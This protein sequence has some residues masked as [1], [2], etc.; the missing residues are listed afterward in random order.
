[1]IRVTGRPS[2]S[3]VTHLSHSHGSLIRV[4]VSHLSFRR[5][6]SDSEHRHFRP[7]CLSAAVETKTRAYNGWNLLL[8]LRNRAANLRLSTRSFE[9]VPLYSAW[10]SAPGPE[11]SGRSIGCHAPL[12]HRSCHAPFPQP[13]FCPSPLEACTSK[14][15]AH[16]H[17]Q[18]TC[19]SA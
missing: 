6:P 16:P 4:A 19:A 9:I 18:G 15:R 12:S 14:G 11:R 17:K 10:D 5:F 2:E 8:R 13:M 7:C 3:R 1:M